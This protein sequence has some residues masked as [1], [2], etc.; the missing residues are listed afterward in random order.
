[1]IAKNDRQ[2]ISQVDGVVRAS[3]SLNYYK[4]KSCGF[5]SQKRCCFSALEKRLNELV[6]IILITF[7]SLHHLTFAL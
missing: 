7:L 1:M 6:E 4:V 3:V 2:P 5:L